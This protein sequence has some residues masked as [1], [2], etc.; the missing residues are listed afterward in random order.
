MI[1]DSFRYFLALA[2]FVAVL[3]LAITLAKEFP[4]KRK[5]PFEAWRIILMTTV[6]LATALF[7]STVFP[8]PR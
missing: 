8:F 3:A 7:V 5:T 4:K 2:T 1:L 6:L